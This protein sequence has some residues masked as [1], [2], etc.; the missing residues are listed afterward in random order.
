MCGHY[1]RDSASFLVIYNRLTLHMFVQSKWLYQDSLLVS[2]YGTI[3]SSVMSKSSAVVLFSQK[4]ALV[5][6][7]T[8]R[9]DNC[10]PVSNAE[11]CLRAP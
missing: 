3:I 1:V 2:G 10:Q 7:Q 4:L 11:C 5:I 8:V 6:W 9:M